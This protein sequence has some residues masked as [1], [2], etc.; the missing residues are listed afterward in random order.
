MSKLGNGGGIFNTPAAADTGNPSAGI[1]LYTSYI[2]ALYAN[3]YKYN[4]S[5]N[6]TFGGRLIE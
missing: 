4:F 1:V 6:K 3:Y 2:F 5:Q